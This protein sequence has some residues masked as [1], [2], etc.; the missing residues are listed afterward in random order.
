M[1]LTIPEQYTPCLSM[2]SLP[3][4]LDTRA[5]RAIRCSFVRRD[6]SNLHVIRIKICVILLLG[7]ALGIRELRGLL[8][9]A[10][11][12]KVL[13]AP[14]SIHGLDAKVGP[15][16]FIKRVGESFGPYCGLY[17]RALAKRWQLGE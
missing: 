14:I 12:S 15:S 10:S 2:R 7:L 9:C 4:Q 8:R 1:Q 16:D 3:R 11:S 6:L 13:R 5:S 17:E